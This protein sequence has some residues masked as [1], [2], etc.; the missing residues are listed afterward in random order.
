VND[1]PETEADDD[2]QP[3]VRW[4]ALRASDLVL[5]AAAGG[6]LA[7]V[8]IIG[9]IVVSRR[10]AT[11]PLTAE[12]LQT[13]RQR[14][15]TNGPR[16]YRMDI[17]V[18]GRQPSRYHVEVAGGNPVVVQRNDHDIPRRN[19]P[20]WTVPGLF[21][22]IEHDVDCA[23]DPTNGFGARPGSTAVLRADVDERL[24]Y[25][26]KFERLILGEPQLDMTWEVTRFEEGIRR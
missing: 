5:G 14:W 1:E 11:A 18:R 25:P 21:D 23:E 2:V 19:W 22:V 10:Q 3:P 24:G 26:R 15:Q 13:A 9:L 4:R 7:L 20:Y 8:A 12:S 17:T 16:D 6:L